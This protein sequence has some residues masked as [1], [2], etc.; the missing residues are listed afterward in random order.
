MK[1]ENTLIYLIGF[2]GAGKFTVAH[3]LQKLIPAVIVDN[4][5]ILNPVFT[6]IEPDG[7]TPLPAKVWENAWKI[8]HIVLDTIR[9]LA[10][11]RSNFIFTNALVE[12]STEDQQLFGEIETLAKERGAKLFP[13]RLLVSADTLC[14]RVTSP[15]RKERYKTTDPVATREAA[16]TYT[17]LKPPEGGLDIETTNLSPLE[18]AKL[19][20]EGLERS[21][22]V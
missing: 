12:G 19:I 17:L 15:E 11:P 18:A 2:P 22:G 21:I 13:V 8:R 14:E 5:L 1:I 16:C 7:K 3:E 6:V 10:K 4:H 20:V 9:E